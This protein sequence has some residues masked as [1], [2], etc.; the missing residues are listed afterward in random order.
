MAASRSL[1]PKVVLQLLDGNR[2]VFV[3]NGDGPEFQQ[4]QERIPG[5]EV[6]GAVFEILGRQQYLGGVVAAEGRKGPL[7]GLDQKALPDGR[8]GLEPWQIGRPLGHAQ[9]SHSGPDRTRTDQHHFPPAVDYVMKL[10]GKLV[11]AGLIELAIVAG[12]DLCADFDDERGGEGGDFL[13]QYVGHDSD[14][15]PSFLKHRKLHSPPNWPV[16]GIRV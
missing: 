15:I 10:P 8:N 11:D 14:S 13:S 4:G 5:V 9:A 7:V 6:A 1:S 12:Q 16:V 3:D 2:I